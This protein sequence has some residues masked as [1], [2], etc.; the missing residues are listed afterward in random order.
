MLKGFDEECY[1]Y[2][3]EDNIF[4]EKIKKLD[5]KYYIINDTAIHLFH[6]NNEDNSDIYYYFKESNKQLFNDYS[7]L[8][9]DGIIEKINSINNWGEK[10]ESKSSDISIRHL[11]RELFEQVSSEIIT[12]LSN[13]FTDDYIN[14]LVNNISSSIYNTIINQIRE[15]ITIDF[16]DIKFN[17]EKKKSLIKRI[18][19]KFRL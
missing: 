16:N 5:L 1:G 17:D 11:K 15:K 6:K 13:K 14:E 3:Y 10:N 4:D 8:N 12:S 18:M 19:N 7:L 9:K 2:G